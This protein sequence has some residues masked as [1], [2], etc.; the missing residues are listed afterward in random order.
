MSVEIFL[1]EVFGENVG[2]LAAAAGV[3]PDGV[4]YNGCMFEAAGE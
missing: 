2:D 3:L 4:F 1:D